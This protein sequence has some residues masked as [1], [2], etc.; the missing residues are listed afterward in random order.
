VGLGE[1][2]SFEC[3]LEW[4]ASS[5]IECAWVE[6]LDEVNGGGW[7]YIYNHQ[8]LPS[9]CS[10]SSDR[11]RSVS[12]VRTVRP[13]TSMAEIATVSGNGYIN[14]YKCIKCVVR[15]QTEQLRTVREDAKNTFYWTCHL[16]VFLVFQRPDDPRLRPDGPRLVSDGARFSFGQSEV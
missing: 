3:V 10:F 16:P 7:G 14:I 15:C 6:C 4:I 2:G 5:C 9:R 1:I 13:Y 11:G 12:L 8:P